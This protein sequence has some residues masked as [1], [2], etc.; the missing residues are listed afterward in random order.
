MCVCEEL[1]DCCSLSLFAITHITHNR[2]HV[3]SIFSVY[4]DVSINR[5]SPADTD[6]MSYLSI[7]LG[8]LAEQHI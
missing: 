2:A 4:R 6:V 7:A 8:S 1:R 5:H 3:G